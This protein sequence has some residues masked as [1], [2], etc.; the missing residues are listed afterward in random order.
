[1]HPPDKLLEII[2]AQPQVTVGALAIRYSETQGVPI[3]EAA[4]HVYQAWSREEI[5]L[6]PSPKENLVQYINS[7]H[8]LQLW[9]VVALY[10]L[11]LASN[12]ILPQ[13]SPFIYLRNITGV[14]SVVLLP[15]ATLIYFLYPHANDLEPL[16]RL[17]YSIG[18]SLA[19][20]TLVG[21]VLNYTS[22]GIQA[23]TAILSLALITIG[24]TL[25]TVRRNYL[26][27]TTT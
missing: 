4:K 10:A 5:R 21:L 2:E 25:L 26:A 17:I 8:G 9:A 13:V 15:G 7:I 1:M 20:T 16:Q 6:E 19:L 27:G 23:S 22:E 14:L 12:F 11:N 3:D 18:L 24:L